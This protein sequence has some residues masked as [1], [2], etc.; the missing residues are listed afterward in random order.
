MNELLSDGGYVTVGRN[1]K[2]PGG[3]L[4]DLYK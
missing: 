2:C 4:I 1:F 3:M